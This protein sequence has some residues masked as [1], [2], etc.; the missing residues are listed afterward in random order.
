M[1][2]TGDP[3]LVQQTM[4]HADLQTTRIYLHP[5]VQQIKAVINRRNQENQKATTRNGGS[6][7]NR[8]AP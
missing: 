6:E 8:T 1:E 4:G 3:A 7:E 2:A 5:N